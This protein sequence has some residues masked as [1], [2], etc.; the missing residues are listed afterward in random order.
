MGRIHD[1]EG[2][3]ERIITYGISPEKE[4]EPDSLNAMAKV[5]KNYWEAEEER[6]FEQFLLRW[7]TLNE[8]GFWEVMEKSLKVVL[9]LE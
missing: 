8:S 4:E 6:R 2:W 1:L 9:G 7:K 5:L 3:S